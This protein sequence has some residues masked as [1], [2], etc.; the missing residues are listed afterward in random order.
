MLT[1][2]SQAGG[3]ALGHGDLSLAPISDQAPTAPQSMEIGHEKARR[4]KF[5]TNEQ[6][7][8]SGGATD[9]SSVLLQ[10]L[11]QLNLMS[12]PYAGSFLYSWLN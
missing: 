3:R 9:D 11:Y 6:K 4:I 12:F 8:N 1:V 2:E 5:K 10:A 7:N